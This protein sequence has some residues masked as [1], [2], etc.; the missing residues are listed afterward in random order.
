MLSMLIVQLDLR[1]QIMV[2]A[3]GMGRDER[4]MEAWPRVALKSGA[5]AV[6]FGLGILAAAWSSDS[7]ARA[8][9]NGTVR[10]QAPRFE[11]LKSDRV[12]LRNGP[13]HEYAISWVL[14]RVGLPVEVLREV[15]GWRQ[16]RDADGTTGW[17]PNSLLSARRTAIVVA[18]NQR[19]VPGEAKSLELRGG[20]SETASVKT[21]V[22]AGRVLAVAACD[23]N[24]CEVAADDTKGHVHQRSLWG[25]YPGE[26]IR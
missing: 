6:A 9:Q 12:P 13:G 1:R 5:A 2:F 25:V 4:R 18:P 21:R 23:G 19:T 20:A 15:D 3:E 11:S 26:R 8:A 24:W 17:V 10:A 14:T 7:G 22:E 16:V